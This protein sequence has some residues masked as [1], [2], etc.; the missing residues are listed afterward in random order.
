MGSACFAGALPPSR[1]DVGTTVVKPTGDAASGIRFST[2]AH[3]ASA[4]SSQGEN[5]DFGA[6]YVYERVEKAGGDIT[7]K[8]VSDEEEESASVSQGAYL[9]VERVL[10]RDRRNNQRTWLGMRGEYL[11]ASE[12]DGGPTLSALAR[13]NWEVYGQVEGAGATDTRCGAAMGFAYGTMGLG[14]YAEAGARRSLEGVASFAATVGLSVRL[15][16]LGGFGF[17]LCPN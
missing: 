10:H 7:D 11:H 16:F 4:A 6:G 9:S 15:P 2:G 8:H 14:F 5:Y 17:D 1:T 13:L 12:E 3:W